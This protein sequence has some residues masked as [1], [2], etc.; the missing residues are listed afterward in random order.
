M[1]HT[2]AA[3]RDIPVFMARA[4][5]FAFLFPLLLLGCDAKSESKTREPVEA[6]ARE[7]ERRTPKDAEADGD[8]DKAEQSSDSGVDAEVEDKAPDGD[9]FDACIRAHMMEARSAESI[10][11]GCRSECDGDPEAGHSA[12]AV[13]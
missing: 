5:A 4:N 7:M 13:N 10:E 9:C 2:V 11:Q 1:Q 12:P 8:A 3:F 6:T